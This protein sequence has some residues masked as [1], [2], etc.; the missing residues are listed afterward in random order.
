MTDRSAALLDRAAGVLLGMAAGDALGAPYEFGPPLPAATAVTM[1]GGPR[2]GRAAGEWTDDTAMA[3]A[4]AEVAATGADLREPAAQDRLV[5]RWAEWVA[6]APDAGAQTRA[7]LAAADSAASARGAA[8]ALHARTGRS[9][10]NGSLMRTAP[11]A[12]RHLDD[13]DGLVEAAGSLS[14]LTHHDP[15]AG[16][17]C[18]LWCLAIRQAVLTGELD[19]RIGLPHLAA[20]RAAVWRRRLDAAEASRPQDFPRNGWVVEALQGAWS[21]IATTGSG[22]RTGHL[23]RALEA[24]VRGGNDTDTVAAIAGALLGAASGASAVPDGWRAQLHGWPG[25]RADGL[26]GLAR[27]ALAPG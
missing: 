16:E 12:L 5:A 14:A 2:H 13:V 27:A 25:L 20:P 9:A 6:G 26:A 1:R 22:G 3:V 18:V 23:P 19:A 17:A 21:A 11:L 15:E 4:I 10:G 7:V 24:A 8:R